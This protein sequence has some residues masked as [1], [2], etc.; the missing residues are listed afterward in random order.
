MKINEYV[1]V[2]RVICWRTSIDFCNQANAS[3]KGVLIVT[4]TNR[5]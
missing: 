4:A 2:D 3:R 5:F 1:M